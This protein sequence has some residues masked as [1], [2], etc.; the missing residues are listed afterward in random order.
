MSTAIGNYERAYRNFKNKNRM[1]HRVHTERTTMSAMGPS[2]SSRRLKKNAVP[3]ARRNAQNA[4]LRYKESIRRLKNSI[5]PLIGISNNTINAWQPTNNVVD[6]VNLYIRQ[7]INMYRTFQGRS[8]AH[9]IERAH[10]ARKQRQVT[11]AYLGMTRNKNA[12]NQN[13]PRLTKNEARA[14]TAMAFNSSANRT[15]ILR[16]LLTPRR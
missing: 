13:K 6:E 3:N 10:N 12:N 9:A 7:R 2:R 11:S 15:A 4:F 16:R 14:I 1:F 5:M 8:L